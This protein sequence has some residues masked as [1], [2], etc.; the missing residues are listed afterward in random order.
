MKVHIL[1]ASG[2][3]ARGFDSTAI[4]VNDRVLLDAGS[5][6]F[7]LPAHNPVRDVVISHSHLDHTMALP[8]L[9]D[10]GGG[11]GGTIRIHA[12]A[13]TIDAL[14]AGLFNG[15][16]WPDMEKIVVNGNPFIKFCPI[17]KMFSPVTIGGARLSFFP[18]V[19]AV[20]TLGFCLHGER[21]DLPIM[22]DMREANAE[23]WEKLTKKRRIGRIAVETSFPD[24]ME[25]VAIDSGH[26][27]PAMLVALAREYFPPSWKLLCCHL[28]PGYDAQI[29]AQIRK[30][31][32]KRAAVLKAGQAFYL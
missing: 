6:A 14:R 29:R 8:F 13:E 32:G 20:P 28:K 10:N 23:V 21:E 2:S 26:L 16:I 4:L 17:G 12:L 24:E 3:I 9:A 25:N 27:T 5:G 7:R 1:G 18:V 11:A 19:H 22:T 15:D 31:F 30:H